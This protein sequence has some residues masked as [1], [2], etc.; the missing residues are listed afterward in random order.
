MIYV[1]KK[2][3]WTFTIISFNS[4]AHRHMN[5]V[6]HLSTW[7]QYLILEVTLTSGCS[8]C[9]WREE[10]YKSYVLCINI[11]EKYVRQVLQL[12]QKFPSAKLLHYHCIW[13]STH[14]EQKGHALA[15]SLNS[16]PI[17]GNRLKLLTTGIHG[18]FLEKKYISF[19]SWTFS[20]WWQR[21]LFHYLKRNI[22]K[23]LPSYKA[24]RPRR[25]Y[26]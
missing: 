15:Q 9:P 21:R 23:H 10:N 7:N 12:G 25:W 8:V 11:Y 14:K 24:S 6:R 13:P 22:G 3:N 1:G 2:L 17:Y 26:S 18:C 16:L 5:T 20:W 19:I 4:N